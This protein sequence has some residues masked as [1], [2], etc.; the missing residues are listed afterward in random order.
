MHL[1]KTIQANNTNNN[2]DF[3][4]LTTMGDIR[5]VDLLNRPVTRAC[6]EYLATLGSRAGFDDGLPLRERLVASYRFLSLPSSSN[7]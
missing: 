6:V 4:V 3:K 7:N 2:K 5:S 1:C